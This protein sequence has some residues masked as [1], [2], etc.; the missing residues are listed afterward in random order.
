MYPAIESAD[1]VV[2]DFTSYPVFKV[3]GGDII[4]G[5]IQ[6]FHFVL[7]DQGIVLKIL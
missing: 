7:P 3:K 6:N 4:T 5:I 2:S 1:S